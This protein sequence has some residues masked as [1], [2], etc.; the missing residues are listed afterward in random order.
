MV[1]FGFLNTVYSYIFVCINFCGNIEFLWI[2]H[3]VVLPMFSYKRMVNFI[4]TS[5]KTYIL[6]SPF[7]TKFTRTETTWKKINQQRLASEITEDT[8]VIEMCIFCSK[9]GTVN[10]I[11]WPDISMI[12]TCHDKVYSSEN[13]I[14]IIRPTDKPSLAVV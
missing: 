7:L 2:L 9:M 5:S 11:T 10:I 13:M 4:L 3:F 6:C 8:F 1:C 14:Y 12:S